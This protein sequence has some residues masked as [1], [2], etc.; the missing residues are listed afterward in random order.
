MDDPKEQVTSIAGG[1]SFT[2]SADALELHRPDGGKKENP[3]VSETIQ[4]LE[5]FWIMLD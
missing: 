5:G 2:F 3:S 1:W 4:R